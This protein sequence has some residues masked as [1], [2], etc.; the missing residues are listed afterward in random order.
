VILDRLS[1]GGADPHLDRHLAVHLL[2]LGQPTLNV[3]AGRKLRSSGGLELHT[4]IMFS[5]LP[6]FAF[7]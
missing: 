4:M 6:S 5:D 2:V 3:N 7:V 1:R